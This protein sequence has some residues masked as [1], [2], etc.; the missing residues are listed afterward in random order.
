M[1]LI[2][3]ALCL[4]VSCCATADDDTAQ[5]YRTIMLCDSL[6][7][8]VGYNRCDIRQ[9]DELVSADFEFYH[10]QAGFTGTRAEFIAGVRDGLCKLSYKAS[11]KLLPHTMRVYPLKK[12]GVLYGAVQTGAH[13]FYATEDGKAQHLTSTALFTHVWLLEDGRWRLRRSL[14]YDHKDAVN[15]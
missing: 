1:K 15:K 5:L 3:T 10:D 6:L 2:L 4:L 9:F 13:E 11:R 12:N 8:D 7:F 14:S